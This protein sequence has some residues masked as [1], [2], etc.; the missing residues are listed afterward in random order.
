VL[1]RSS[2]GP[3]TGPLC[4]SC[5]SAMRSANLTGLTFTVTPD[6]IT[7]WTDQ[8]G[9]LGG[10][11]L[12]SERL[13]TCSQDGCCSW[14]PWSGR[15]SRARSTGSRLRSRFGRAASAIV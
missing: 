1:A 8:R 9:Q 12:T 13:K 2:H 10:M 15:L 4:R 5:A 7:I 3:T 6:Q 11:L 14:A